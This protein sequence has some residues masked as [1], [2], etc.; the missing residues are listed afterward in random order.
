MSKNKM[1]VSGFRISTIAQFSGEWALGRIE[2]WDSYMTMKINDVS[3]IVL[4]KFVLRYPC[5]CFKVKL[6]WG[7]L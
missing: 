2:D 5:I 1:L 7:P 6:D 4:G 3:K